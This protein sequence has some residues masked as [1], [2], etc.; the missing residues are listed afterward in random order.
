MS[1]LPRKDSV[2][3]TFATGGNV[4]PARVES[5]TAVSDERPFTVDAD[6]TVR[7]AKCDAVLES[8]EWD[9]VAAHRCLSLVRPS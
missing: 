3:T 7:C 1:D 9:V 8:S 5:E 4:E 2:P 6:G